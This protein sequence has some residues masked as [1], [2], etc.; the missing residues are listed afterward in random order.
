VANSHAGV[1]KPQNAKAVL[2]QNREALKVERVHRFSQSLC[3][4]IKG[5]C[6]FIQGVL[7]GVRR[8]ISSQKKIDPETGRSQN[9][10]EVGGLHQIPKFL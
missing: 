5:T 9:P 8:A 7:V 2:V 1:L 3:Q 4:G 10:T 6:G